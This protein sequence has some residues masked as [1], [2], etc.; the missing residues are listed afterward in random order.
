ME[1][2]Q[3]YQVGDRVRAIWPA[4]A[5]LFGSTGTICTVFFLS[6]LYDV[7][8]DNQPK[9]QLV[10]HNDLELLRTAERQVS[11]AERQVSST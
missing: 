11:T 4:N 2:S 3:R 8:F 6:D 7:R 1:A 9:L 10:R 5:I